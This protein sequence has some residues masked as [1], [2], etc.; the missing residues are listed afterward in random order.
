MIWLILTAAALTLTAHLVAVVYLADLFTR[1][2]RRRVE[3]TPGDLDLRYEDVMFAAPDGVSLRGWYVD[4]PGARATVVLVHDSAGNRS[5]H[6]LLHLQRDYVHHG[7]RVLAFDLR[8]RGESGGRRDLLGAAEEFDLHAAVAYARSRSPELPVLVHGFGLG[9]ALAVTAAT[10]DLP[11]H[12]VIADSPF[13][14]ARAALRLR[15]PRVPRY[16]FAMACVAARRL[17]GADTRVLSPVT[18]VATVTEGASTPIL[19]I[20][21]LADEHVPVAHTFNLAAASLHGDDR[22]WTVEAAGHCRSYVEHPETYLRRCL[23]FVEAAIPAR[24]P[25]AAAG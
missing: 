15:W 3:G 10:G 2:K 14:S 21:G 18:T 23:D 17:F 25:L 11:L 16:L 5:A 20:H 1:S 22:V 12:A 6:G 24:L 4:S 9:A 19:F 8:G 13:T 7:F